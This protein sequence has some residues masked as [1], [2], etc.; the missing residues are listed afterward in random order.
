[1]YKL[2]IFD[3]DGT[4]LNTIA[5]ISDSLNYALGKINLPL[6][7]LET[8]KYMVGQGV[9]VLIDKAV[10]LANSKNAYSLV[11]KEYLAHYAL[12]QRNKTSP[13]QWIREVITKLK[14]LGLKLAVYSNKPHADTIAVINYYFGPTLFDYVLGHKPPNRPKPATDGTMEILEYFKTLARIN[15]ADVLFVG[16]TSVDMATAKNAALKSVAVTW[17]FRK[18]EEIIPHHYL[19]NE[20]QELLTIIK[21]KI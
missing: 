13:Y 7:D 16:D 15:K 19:I 3:L 20:P 11:K 1:M 4:L 6:V 8:C 2:V 14:D 18:P 12:N 10:G 5:D 9:D 21:E 17:G